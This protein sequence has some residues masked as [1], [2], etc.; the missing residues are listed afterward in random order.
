MHENANQRED[1]MTDGNELETPET[2]LNA[3]ELADKLQLPPSWIY[4][5]ADELGAYRLGKYLRFSFRRVLERLARGAVGSSDIGSPTQ[6][7]VP[8][9]TKNGA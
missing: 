2:L 8:S 6:R 4:D 3:R 5:H 7:P 1:S 9:H